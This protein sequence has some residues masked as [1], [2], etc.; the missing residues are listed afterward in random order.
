[1][2]KCWGEERGRTDLVHSS[3]EKWWTNVETPQGGKRD[4]DIGT[5]GDY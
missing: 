5:M 1:M 4:A 3:G 2:E